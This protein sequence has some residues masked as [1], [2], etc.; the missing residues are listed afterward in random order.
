MDTTAQ[1]LPHRPFSFGMA[2]SSMGVKND[3]AALE[4]FLHFPEFNAVELPWEILHSADSETARIREKIFRQCPERICGS[5]MD[6]RLSI[7]IPFADKRMRRDFTAQL[8]IALEKLLP[9]GITR[10][11]LECRPDTLEPGSDAG[12]ALTEIL[13]S[14]APFLIRNTMILLLPA[15]VPPPH[16][17]RD[18]S[19]TAQFL[20]DCMI[21]NIKLRLDVHP[22]DL[23]KGAVPAQTAG[24]LAFE[25]E[26]L[27]FHYNADW[28]NRIL[29]SQVAVW[30]DY[31]AGAGHGCPLLLSPAS[32]RNRMAFPEAELFAKIAGELAAG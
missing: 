19:A 11:V 31:L 25:T 9:H 6:S 32:Q 15:A 14:I 8:R 29:K 24:C 17:H 10:A 1:T 30:K 12:K 22:W 28:G 20:R 16:G 27:L 4:D 23:K 18:A 5:V 26:A 2:L 7:E 3:P 21:P 13:H